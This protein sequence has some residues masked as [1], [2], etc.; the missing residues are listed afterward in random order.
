MLLPLSNLNGVSTNASI[1]PAGAPSGTELRTMAPDLA[2][3][4]AGELEDAVSKDDPG[5]VTGIEAN[6]Q[7][8]VLSGRAH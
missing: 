2:V 1:F 7:L 4:V 6:E 3:G 8:R 5:F